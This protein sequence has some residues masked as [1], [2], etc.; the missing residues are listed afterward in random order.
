MDEPALVLGSRSRALAELGERRFDLLVVGGGIVGAGV[1]AVAAGHGLAVAL[2]D[3]GDFGGGT[4]SASSK[5]VHGGLR[6]LRLGDIGLV[7]EAHQERR[8]LM[9]TVAPHLVHRL[10]FLFPL[11]E[12]GPYRPWFVQSGIVLYSTLARARL[13]GLVAPD[14]ARRMVPE[15]RGAGLRSCALYADAW[16]NDA[17]LT[18]ANVRAAAAAGATVLNYAEVVAL[19]GAEG[20][21]VAADGERV[22]VRARAVVN[23]A[24]PWVDHVRRLEEPAAGRSI[25]LSKGVHVVI[26]PG[27][28]W[29][30]ALTVPHDQVRVTFAVPWHGMLLLGTTDTLYEGDPGDAACA[31]EDIAQVLDEASVALDPEL[32]RRDRVRVAFAGL[33]VLPGGDGETADARRETVYSRGPAGMLSVAGGKLTTYRRIALEVLGRLRSD[34]GLHRIDRQPRPLPGA[35]GLDRVSLP[36]ELAPPVR[37]HLLNLYGTLAAEVLAPAVDD[38]SL[39][40]PLRPDGPDLAAQALYATTHEWAVTADDVL[41]RRTTAWLRGESAR[42]RSTTARMLG[43]TADS[44]AGR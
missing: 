44:I 28:R 5:L 16:T 1:A 6:Y 25:R 15:L 21:E 35:E 8:A 24:G 14:R 13:N 17:R 2:V 31:E 22:T 11:Y 27:A 37:G 41:R 38:P 39:L 9:G 18:L 32:V 40:D 34:L 4:S 19:R 3:R 26:D 20:A 42:A 10:P 36:V 12:Q 33:R 43:S 7:R 23:A 29:P 30:C